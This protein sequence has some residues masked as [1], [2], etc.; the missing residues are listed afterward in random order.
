MVRTMKV[1]VPIVGDEVDGEIGVEMSI[2]CATCKHKTTNLDCKSFS[3]I[4]E[5]IR[6]C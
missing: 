1:L 2:Q 3:P 4:P 6:G 5:A